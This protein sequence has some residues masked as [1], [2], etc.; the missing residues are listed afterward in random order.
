MVVHCGSGSDHA[1]LPFG[2]LAEWV[3]PGKQIAENLDI[4]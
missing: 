1:C 2:F 3:V 4:F